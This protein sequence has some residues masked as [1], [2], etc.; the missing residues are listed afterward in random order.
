MEVKNGMKC[1]GACR[2]TLVQVLALGSLGKKGEFVYC[3]RR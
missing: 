1:G 3:K 2:L